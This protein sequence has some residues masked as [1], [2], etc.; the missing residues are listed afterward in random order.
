[1]VGTVRG[2]GYDNTTWGKYLQISAVNNIWKNFESLTTKRNYSNY[3][4]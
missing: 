3:C 2:I 1:M 4:K